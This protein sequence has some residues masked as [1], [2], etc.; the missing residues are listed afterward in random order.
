MSLSVI[1]FSV[2]LSL[3]LFHFWNYL[4]HCRCKLKEFRFFLSTK[5]KQTLVN[6]QCQKNIRFCQR[7]TNDWWWWW[8]WTASLRMSQSCVRG[9]SQTHAYPYKH[10]RQLF[11]TMPPL[12]LCFCFGIMMFIAYLST[13]TKQTGMYCQIRNVEFARKSTT[14]SSHQVEWKYTHQLNFGIL[15]LLTFRI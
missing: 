11:V 8:Q 12:I 13:H 15:F 6:E 1:L 3:F 5:L 4:F 2:F 10:T 14:Y 9:H 7:T